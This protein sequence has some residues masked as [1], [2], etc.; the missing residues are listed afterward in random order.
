MAD[1]VPNHFTT[2]FSTNWLL[3][4]QQSKARLDEFVIDEPFDGERK[5][6]NRIAAQ[7]SRERTERKGPTIVQDVD[8]D[9]RWG[10]RK[11]YD[12]CNLLDKDDAVNLGKLVL[13]TSEYVAN[14]AN[15][16]NRDKDA[17]AFLA[18]LNPAIIGANGESTL[19]L[20]SAQKIVAG[21]TGLT[22][23]KLREANAILM[24]ADFEDDAPR[25]IVVTAEQIQNLLG[26]TEVTSADYN[27]VK[28]LVA[29]HV[30]TFLGFKFKRS[31]YLPKAST[32]RSCVAWVKGAIKRFVGE[33]FNS[34][35]KRSDLSYATQIYSSWN[36]GA[37][38]VQDELVV[39][40]DCIEAS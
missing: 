26:T 29:G 13:P 11:L 28:A 18:A 1:N 15:A 37:A 7:A 25:V 19:A 24:D 21:G 10:Q 17:T 30:D 38:R 3:R 23:A 5:R 34:I 22:V 14:H 4:T 27:S 20:P 36:L 35:D 39:Q 31:K 2:E 8:S 40:I 9:N 6:W 16:F 33:K 12:C 32:T